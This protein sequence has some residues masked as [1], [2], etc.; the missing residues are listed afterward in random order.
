MLST[1]NYKITRI[2]SFADTLTDTL[3][4]Q[5]QFWDW[6]RDFWPLVSNCETDIDTFDMQP[7]TLR[8]R[9]SFHRSGLKTQDWDWTTQVSVLVSRPK[10]LLT[11]ADW[12]PK[13]AARYVFDSKSHYQTTTLC[14]A[15]GIEV[16][17]KLPFSV[18][19]Y[20]YRM[21]AP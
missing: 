19:A 20:F 12:Q 8:P 17:E 21:I 15:L 6:D 3:L 9:L 18:S 14:T 11:S 13:L 7:Q 2:H 1:S 10:V 5:S 4:M 16:W